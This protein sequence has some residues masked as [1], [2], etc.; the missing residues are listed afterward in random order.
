MRGQPRAFGCKTAS[1]PPSANNPRSGH[2]R[3][4]A[5][6]RDR[7][8]FVREAHMSVA[9]G[10]GKLVGRVWIVRMVG[11]SEKWTF[12]AH[13]KF[14]PKGEFDALSNEQ[15]A[16]HV[17]RYTPSR[18][19]EVA[20]GHALYLD[21]GIRAGIHRYPPLP[22]SEPMVCTGYDA[23]NDLFIEIGSGNILTALEG[24]V[25]MI[26]RAHNPPILRSDLPVPGGPPVPLD[27]L[28]VRPSKIPRPMAGVDSL[29]MQAMRHGTP[30][31][32]L[33]LLGVPYNGQLS[34]M[35]LTPAG[36]PTKEGSVLTPTKTRSVRFK[37]PPARNAG[38]HNAGVEPNEL[39]EASPEPVV[40]T[41][42]R[43]SKPRVLSA[44]K[45]LLALIGSDRQK[46]IK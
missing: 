39:A 5:Y 19:T 29:S 31:K 42:S 34:S 14:W 32:A 46:H 22:D 21:Y 36:E 7:V 40:E 15:K 28:R 8:P 6:A 26:S 10:F 27:S 17:D 20:P 30:I 38:S 3:H 45:S 18:H 41:P 44:K 25:E 13:Q 4:H 2:R 9:D 24:S 23:T 12:E 33:R 35:P 1:L 37:A 11:F 43:A 16:F